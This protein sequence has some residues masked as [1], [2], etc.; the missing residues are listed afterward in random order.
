MYIHVALTACR[1]VYRTDDYINQA[2]QGVCTVPEIF[3]T[4]DFT[5]LDIHYKKQG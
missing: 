1:N 5:I 3:T 2:A 4:C